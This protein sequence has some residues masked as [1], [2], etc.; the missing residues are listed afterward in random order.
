MMHLHSATNIFGHGVW[1]RRIGGGC[2]EHEMRAAL[3]RVAT[4]LELSAA[5]QTLWT[6]FVEKLLSGFAASRAPDPG[7][8]WDLGKS[9]ALDHMLRLEIAAGRF[10]GAIEEARESF[11][12]VHA[13]LTPAQREV[14][15]DAIGGWETSM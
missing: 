14:L 15:D 1:T 6:F 8:G 9:P 7:D 11:G 4:R 3:A 10:L 12:H 5:Q 2:G 13:I